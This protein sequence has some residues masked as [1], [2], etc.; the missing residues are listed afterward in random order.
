MSGFQ[1]REGQNY[2]VRIQEE[3]L[4]PY[5]RDVPESGGRVTFSGIVRPTEDGK[6][7]EALHYEAYMEMAVKSLENIVRD[8]ISVYSVKYV[9]AAHRTGRV[10]AGEPSV[11]VDAFAEHR[12]EAFKACSLII[13]RIKK[14]VP[15]WKK[16]MYS[17]GSY[18][19]KDILDRNVEEVA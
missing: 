13:D 7:I 16:V 3:A 11:I 9:F 15:V 12:S 1:E 2:C 19:W 10:R 14:E 6:A 5:A 8:A 18:Q 4:I 17:D